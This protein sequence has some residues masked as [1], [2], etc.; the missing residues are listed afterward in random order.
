ML[1]Y[2]VRRERRLSSKIDRL[3]NCME[4]LEMKASEALKGI[5]AN[6][7]M[8]RSTQQAQAALL[9]GQSDLESRIADLKRQIGEGNSDPD[10]SGIDQALQEQKNLIQGLG[11]AIPANTSSENAAARADNQS[12]PRQEQ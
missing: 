1:D 3:F 10:V 7:D 5:T 9:E 11:K 8:L 4:N 6:N 12:P 2:F